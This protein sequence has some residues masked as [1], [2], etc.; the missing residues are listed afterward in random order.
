MKDMLDSLRF[1][2]T[3]CDLWKEGWNDTDLL[4][5]DY[6]GKEIS[7]QLVRSLGSISANIEEGYGRG[8]GQDYSR[9]LR[10]ARGSARETRGWY[11]RSGL[12]LPAVTVNQRTEKLD[13][14]IAALTKSI[15]TLEQKK[16]ITP[17]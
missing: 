13:F 4:G 8:Y 6:R 2:V 15:R 12:L 10:I 7:K 9:F 1:Y 3:A 5:N 14:V 11:V 16:H 17:Y